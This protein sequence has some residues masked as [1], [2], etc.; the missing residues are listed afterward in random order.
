MWTRRY[1][2][3][4]GFMGLSTDA[5]N[6]FRSISYP[7]R[8]RWMVPLT[9]GCTFMSAGFLIR[10]TR[11]NHINAWAYIFETFVSQTRGLD[12]LSWPRFLRHSWVDAFSLSSSPPAFPLL[13][14]TSSFPSFLSIS[15]LTTA[16]LL[17]DAGLSSYWSPPMSLRSSRNSEEPVSKRAFNL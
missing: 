15:G 5:L 10:F 4:S 11:R 9:V 13:K 14:I 3:A 8:P 16:L 7:A 1:F 6:S 17:S 2:I 12:S